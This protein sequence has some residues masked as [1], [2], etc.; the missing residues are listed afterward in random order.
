[1]IPINFLILKRHTRSNFIE[2][3]KN[4]LDPSISYRSAMAKER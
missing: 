4:R 2:L 1:M 3:D